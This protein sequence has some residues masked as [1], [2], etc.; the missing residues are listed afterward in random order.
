MWYLLFLAGILGATNAAL[1]HIKNLPKLRGS[2]EGRLLAYDLELRKYRLSYPFKRRA[3]LVGPSYVSRL[4]SFQE[5]H[6]L[7]FTG[8]TPS[9]I[10]GIIE[11]YCRKN[12]SIYYGFTL[13]DLFQREKETE[14]LP[15]S[16]LQRKK[17][18]VKALFS[19]ECEKPAKSLFERQL[20]RIRNIRDEDIRLG[21]KRLARI[22]KRHPHLR[23]I[24]FPTYPE[25]EALEKTRR[26]KQLLA[27]ANVPL[28]DMA[29]TLDRNQFT[30]CFHHTPDG[31]K[32]LRE[33]IVNM[34]TDPILI[35]VN[36]SPEIS[37]ASASF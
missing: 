16:S 14:T 15:F 35:S 13:F 10:E 11:R 2:L 24:M 25:K 9:E 29:D 7:G 30:D 8:A 19:H 5:I 37:Y 6:N 31:V 26:V 4:G 3:V 18:I 33:H 21:A 1:L 22:C 36:T 27:R 28:I 34:G 32:A 17:L 12:D 23:V 20:R